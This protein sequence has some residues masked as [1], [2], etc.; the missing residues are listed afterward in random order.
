MA[1]V[2]LQAFGLSSPDPQ[3]KIL[4]WNDQMPSVSSELRLPAG[5]EMLGGEIRPDDN[6]IFRSD[7]YTDKS[8]VVRDRDGVRVTTRE[9]EDIFE[10]GE[11]G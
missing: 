3:D 5:I 1:K 10:R 2:G 9:G 7:I 8:R 4:I 11:N 6:I